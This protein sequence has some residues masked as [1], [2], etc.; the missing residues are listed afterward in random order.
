MHDG[1]TSVAARGLVRPFNAFGLAM[2]LAGLL[3]ACL[4]LGSLAGCGQRGPLYLDPA[5]LGPGAASSSPTALT[6]SAPLIP[7]STEPIAPPVVFPPSP[8]TIK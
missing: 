2:A 8:P 4:G 6:G 7:P 3:A 5:A 1:D